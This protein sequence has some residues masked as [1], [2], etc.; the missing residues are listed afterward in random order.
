MLKPGWVWYLFTANNVS[1]CQCLYRLLSFLDKILNWDLE[2]MKWF[3]LIKFLHVK[4][5]K[6]SR[7]LAWKFMILK[8]SS[9]QFPCYTWWYL[10]HQYWSQFIQSTYINPWKPKEYVRGNKSVHVSNTNK[11]YYHSKPAKLREE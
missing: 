11:Y 10:Y 4:M 8:Q 6:F 3:C 2:N 7:F 1:F 5:L 9:K